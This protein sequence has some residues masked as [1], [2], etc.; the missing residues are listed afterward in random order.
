MNYVIF[1]IFVLIRE[2]TPIEVHIR[3]RLIGIYPLEA[4]TVQAAVLVAVGSKR[5]HFSLMIML[6]T[7]A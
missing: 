6:T 7:K 2:I 3:S 1:I 5:M 4:L